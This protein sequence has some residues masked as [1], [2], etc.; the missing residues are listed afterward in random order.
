M[1]A[2][3][4]AVAAEQ[5]MSADSMPKSNPKQFHVC[6]PEVRWKPATRVAFRFVFIYF[7]LYCLPSP[8]S[9]FSER[10][11]FWYGAFWDKVVKWVSV[12]IL[13][14]T[15]TALTSPGSG[16][17]TA[18]YIQVLCYLALATVG[19][20]IWTLLDRRRP[21]YQ[22]LYQWLELYVRTSLA[23]ILTVYGAMKV[24]FYQMSQ[25]SLTRLLEPY[26]DSSPM[27][28]LWTFIG[29][30][31]GYSIFCGGVEMLAA[32]LLFVPGCA[33]LGALVAIGAMANVFMLNMCYDV[34]VKQ[35]SFHLLLMAV[36]LAAPNLRRLGELF[37]LGRR[38]ELSHGVPLSSRK[39][40]NRSWLV[41]QLAF[42]LFVTVLSLHSFYQAAHTPPP[43]VSTALSGIWSV[44]EYVVNGSIQPPL[45][46]EQARWQRVVFNGHGASIQTMNG[47]LGYFRTSLDNNKKLVVLTDRD[48]PARKLPFHYTNPQ[49]GTLLLTGDVD[50]HHVTATLRHVEAPKFLLTNRGF[51]WISEQPYIR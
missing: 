19:A 9:F 49:P 13:G 44:D 18:D 12:H 39:W 21:N 1:P 10:P 2:T 7:I 6:V 48:D 15:L 28:L 14:I 30:S 20:T 51:H 40:L 27:S 3:A 31:K 43:L 24:M 25:P 16:D 26:G 46:T 5:E 29:A 47:A 8:L 37:F 32:I 34:P 42:G 50:G 36:F 45:I 35:Y 11:D 22:Q 38:V 17:T 33:T 41:A 4:V 23:A